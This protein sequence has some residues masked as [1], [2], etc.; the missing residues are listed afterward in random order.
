[1]NILRKELDIGKGLLKKAALTITEESLLDLSS[2]NLLVEDDQQVVKVFMG[3][4][5][6]INFGEQKHYA[7][8][9]R[10]QSELGFTSEWLHRVDEFERMIEHHKCSENQLDDLKKRFSNH[11]QYSSNKNYVNNIRE[12]M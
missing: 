3:I 5:E 8:W 7:S 9:S 1:M 4:L 6:L 10:V 11:A 12:F 2:D